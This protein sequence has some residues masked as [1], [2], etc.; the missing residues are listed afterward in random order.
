M[1]PILI[2]VTTPNYIP[3]AVP[4]LQSLPLIVSAESRLV[5]LDFNEQTDPSQATETMLRQH[6][7]WVRFGKM[8][9]PASNSHSMIQHGRFLDA[10][11][12]IRPDSKVIL[13]DMD[14][15]IQRDF[16]ESELR[17][18]ADLDDDEIGVWWNGTAADSLALEADRI[19][20]SREWIE[21]W[22]VGIDLKDF[23]CF[24]CGVMIATART[25]RALQEVYEQ[26]CDE[27]YAHASH[28]SRCQFLLNWCWWKRGLAVEL[29]PG[30]IH[31]HGHFQ[32]PETG[33]YLLPVGTS[34]RMKTVMFEGQ[35]VVFR[36][37]F[38]F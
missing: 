31:A 2:A 25:F 29:L 24:N 7:D 33:E 9:M 34:V 15:V 37:A 27:F 12:D 4:Y 3:R 20:L 18:M 28:R 23:H 10:F 14:I 1:K 8:D 22:C 6:L 17:W 36:H 26:H 30:T 13:T 35:P 32:N 38:S 5:L 19:G 21:R 11:P 16:S